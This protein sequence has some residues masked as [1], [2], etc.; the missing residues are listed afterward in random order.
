MTDESGESW[1]CSFTL[2]AEGHGGEWMWDSWEL[3]IW[4]LSQDTGDRLPYPSLTTVSS[5][6]LLDFWGTDRIRAGEVLRTSR[7]LTR[8]EPFELVMTFRAILLSENSRVSR[9]ISVPCRL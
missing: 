6:G 3:R 7:S 4:A 1:N 2:A 8:E 5:E 9:S